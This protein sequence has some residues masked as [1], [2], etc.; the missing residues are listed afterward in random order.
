MHDRIQRYVIPATVVLMTAAMTILVGAKPLAPLWKSV[1][2][3]GT[4]GVITAI[5]TVGVTNYGLGYVCHAI[6]CVMMFAKRTERFGDSR[7]L[8]RLLK[9]FGSSSKPTEPTEVTDSELDLDRILGQF[10]LRL[11]SSQVPECLRDHCTRRNSAWYI[12]KTCAI[13]ALVGLIVA[14]FCV[15]KSPSITFDCL[16]LSIWIVAV[17]AFTASSWWVGTRWNVE[18]W[19]VALGWVERDNGP[20]DGDDQEGEHDVSQDGESAGAPS[21]PVS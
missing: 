13:A 18:F 1:S 2:T 8:A 6:F 10:H 14:L 16:P 12:A 11:H 21:P 17:V 9:A 15:H 5:I 4:A 7:Y 20:Q 19:E 3:L